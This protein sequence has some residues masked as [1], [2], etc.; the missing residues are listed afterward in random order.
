MSL[1]DPPS[2][3]SSFLPGASTKWVAFL[4]LF[5]SGLL[6]VLLPWLLEDTPISPALAQK[7]SILL[8]VVTLLLVGSLITLFLVV[9]AYH[10]QA[11]KHLSDLEDARTKSKARISL[12]NSP[13]F[14]GR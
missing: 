10:A 5:L 7:L 11:E 2:P 8:P 12:E 13:R 9:R 4:S 14:N 6:Y 3:L 1:I